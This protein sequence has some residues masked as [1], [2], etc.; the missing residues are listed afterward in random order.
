MHKKCGCTTTTCGCCE[1]TQILTPVAIENRPGL[2]AINFRVGTHGSFFETMKA[3]LSTMTVDVTDVSG[4]E[5]TTLRPLLALT[6]RDNTDLTIALLDSWATVGDVLTFYQERIANEGY[7]RT[8]TQRESILELARLVGYKLR[9]G[10]AASVFLAYTIDANQTKPVLIPAGSGAQSIPLQNTN[11]LPQ[12]FETSTDLTARKEWNSLQVRLTRPQNITTDTIWGL[13]A[14]YVDPSTTNIKTGDQLLFVFDQTG[15]G[16]FVRKVASVENQ[17][18]N[19]LIA[20]H[21]QP[22]SPTL[23]QGHALLDTFI[24]GLKA[25]PNANSNS[26]LQQVIG[27]VTALRDSA[28]LGL[29]SDPS[30]WVAMLQK[31]L[32]RE[33]YDLQSDPGAAPLWQ[34]L[35][36][37]LEALSGGNS[38]GNGTT[39]PSTFVSSL[40]VSQQAQPRSSLSLPRS[41]ANIARPG[42]DLQPQLLIDFAPKLQDTFYTA[43]AAANVNSA[44]AALEGVYAL[45]SSAAAYGATAPDQVTFN[46]QQPSVPQFSPWTIASDEASNIF[47]LDQPN[48]AILPSS[49]A[50]VQVKRLNSITARSV[51]QITGVQTGPRNQ[52]GIGGKTT[53]LTFGDDWWKA[54]SILTLQGAYAYEQSEPLTL[55]DEPISD[56]VGAQDAQI[57]LDEVYDG[58]QSGS[59]IIFSGERSDIPG[60][61]GVQGAE[62]AMISGVTQSF[63]STLPGD[64]VHTSIETQTA[65]AYSYNRST[66]S[67]FANVVKA[68]HGQTVNETLGS[69]DGSQTLQSF[70]LSRP[71][72]TYVSAPTVSGAQSTLNVYVNNIQWQETDNLALLGPKDQDFITQTDNTAVTTV[73]FGDGQNGSRLP[74]GVQNVTATYRT[75]IGQPGNVLAGQI[76]MLTSRPLGV[77]GVLNPLDA[78][79]GAD[80]ESLNDARGNVP[81]AVMSLGRIVSVQDYANFARTFAGIGKAQVVQLS[82]GHQQVV[83]L[84]IAGTDDIPIDPT[85][86]LYLNLVEALQNLGDPSVALQVDTRE[87]VT[88]VLGAKVKI[89]PRYL[90]DPVAAQI[91]A[92]LQSQFGFGNRDLAQ[93]ALLCEII[94]AIQNTPGVVYVDVNA[95]GGIPEKTVGQAGPT[96]LTLQQIATRVA[97]ITGLP[98]TNG[99]NGDNQSISITPPSV[100]KRGGI[101]L[102]QIV[103]AKPGRL[104]LG[105]LRPAELAIFSSTV[106]DTIA[107]T[108]IK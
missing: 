91:L 52:Y 31:Q 80:A 99:S 40:L 55:V 35:V 100:G 95:F 45:R 97:M 78:S 82:N 24:T 7:L 103:Q 79:G 96:L 37:G 39:N 54:D 83:Y 58:L 34:Q 33:I 18:A 17:T 41:L 49:F 75:G 90:W 85:S 8:A 65:R 72:L 15:I 48:E 56:P 101:Q 108:Q 11:E 10:V 64:T 25:L 87:L 66:L 22:N 32:E 53:Q 71:P 93:P 74:T 84:T 59:F 57:E 88:L 70:N 89:D 62:F 69:G 13:T 81:L 1:G 28:R 12:P 29:Y 2:P 98:S 92:T 102:P 3:R 50:L 104:E 73:V 86:D 36:A 9:P 14:L 107:L 38:G 46:A 76:S 16:S 42:S 27:A 67:I 5:T 6:T 19:N 21:L 94:A 51:H 77:T 20:I 23:K 47:Y 30:V 61:T 4:T 43:W 63:D 44:V 68:T 105:Y 26:I 60:V 106:P